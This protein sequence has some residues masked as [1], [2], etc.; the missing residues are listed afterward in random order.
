MTSSSEIA[1]ATEETTGRELPVIK[2]D[3]VLEVD[4]LKVSK[5]ALGKIRELCSV[6]A[7]NTAH[8]GEINVPMG[9]INSSLRV[10]V[11][12]PKLNEDGSVPE[13]PQLLGHITK[14]IERMREKVPSD[15]QDLVGIRNAEQIL[16]GLQEDLLVLKSSEEALAEISPDQFSRITEADLMKMVEAFSTSIP[17]VM[18]IFLEELSSISKKE[19]ESKEKK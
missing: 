6:S 5:D 4:R 7:R 17:T 10:A 19:I 2:M 18:G 14:I 9:M 3:A 11:E 8:Q 15:G 12:K 16:V 1:A 13:S